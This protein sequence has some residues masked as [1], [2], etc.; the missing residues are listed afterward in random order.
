M[1]THFFFFLSLFALACTSEDNGP[2]K[3]R[4][5][6]DTAAEDTAAEDT[7]TDIPDWV[8]PDVP[9][10]PIPQTEGTDTLPEDNDFEWSGITFEDEA[11]NALIGVSEAH[12]PDI[13]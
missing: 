3:T 5:N 9:E 12:L 6:E 2:D 1:H 4:D 8:N 11:D 10:G 13:A 7:A